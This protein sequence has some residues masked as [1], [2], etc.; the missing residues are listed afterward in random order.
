[1]KTKSLFA[2]VGFPAV[3]NLLANFKVKAVTLRHGILVGFFA[4]TSLHFVSGK[5]VKT[6]RQRQIKK[7][8]RLQKEQQIIL[9]SSNQLNLATLQEY[10]YTRPCHPDRL[11]YPPFTCV[12]TIGEYCAITNRDSPEGSKDWLR[13]YR[14]GYGRECKEGLALAW[15]RT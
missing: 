5:I 12:L 9:Q 6:C 14:S 10:T 4:N 1:M 15:K 13:D 8:E 3:S 11:T 2:T 7:R